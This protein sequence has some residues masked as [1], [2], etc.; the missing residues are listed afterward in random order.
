[1][2]F[3]RVRLIE[4]ASEK[5]LFAETESGKHLHAVV[6]PASHRHTHALYCMGVW[7]PSSEGV[8]DVR[9]VDGMMTCARE[10]DGRLEIRHGSC[11]KRDTP[12]LPRR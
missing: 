9:Y 10:F 12:P 11:A 1:M 5:Q 6:F 2:L 7:A 3:S 4:T 8:Y